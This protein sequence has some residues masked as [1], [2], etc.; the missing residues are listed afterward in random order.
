MADPNPDDLGALV[1]SPVPFWRSRK[2]WSAVVS[3]AIVATGALTGGPAGAGLALTIAA[4]ILGYM[5][6]LGAA[7]VA[8]AARK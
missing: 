5:G 2:F 3:T 6:L 1:S 8:A 7:D 4:P